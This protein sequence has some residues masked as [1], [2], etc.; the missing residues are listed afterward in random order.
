MI[1]ALGSPKRVIDVVHGYGGRVIADVNSVPYA[2]KAAA[3]GAD[4]LCL[5]SAGAG[6]HTG[7]MAGFAFVPAV[8]EFFDGI[9]VLSGS[10]STGGAIRAAELLG[11]DL[12]YMGTPFIAANESLASD[13]YRDMLVAAEFEDLILSDALTGADAYYLRASLKAMGL[14]ADALERREFKEFVRAEDEVKAWRDCWSAGHG[15]GTVRAIEPAAEII[16]RLKQEYAAA[17]ARPHFGA[18]AE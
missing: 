18:I 1:T 4:G 9:I 6:G 8:R 17:V 2:R 7:H 14:D 5:V 11:A 15:V 13:N 12:A 10:I 3:A 16:A